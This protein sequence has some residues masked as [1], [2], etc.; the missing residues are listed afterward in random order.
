[1]VAGS[2]HQHQELASTSDTAV[3]TCRNVYRDLSIAAMRNLDR[4]AETYPE[5][6]ILLQRRMARATALDAELMALA[7]LQSEGDVPA[8]VAGEV[9]LDVESERYKLAHQS[10]VKLDRLPADVLRHTT[11]LR[12]FPKADFLRLEEK[13]TPRTVLAGEAIIA[14]GQENHSLFFIVQGSVALY[15]GDCPIERRNAQRNASLHAGEFFGEEVLEEEP[16]PC[17]SAVAVTDCRL[18]EFDYPQLQHQFP[19]MLDALK[20]MLLEPD[21]MRLERPTLQWP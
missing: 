2:V 14:P 8:M 11:I 5:Y 6:A 3:S 10:L 13:L 20:M 15:D 18:Y 9:R 4:I 19:H 17:Q 1:M 21:R 12:E 7:A 16:I